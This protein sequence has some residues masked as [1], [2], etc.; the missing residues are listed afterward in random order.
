VGWIPAF[1]NRTHIMT[2]RER[3]HYKFRIAL[4]VYNVANNTKAA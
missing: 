2:P 4:N 3:S 1:K